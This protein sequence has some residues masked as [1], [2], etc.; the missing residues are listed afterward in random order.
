MQL[1]EKE[2]QTRKSNHQ[3]LVNVRIKNNY[4]P[5]PSPTFFFKAG[6]S[7]LRTG[8]KYVNSEKKSGPR[9]GSRPCCRTQRQASVRKPKHVLFL[10]SAV[11]MHDSCSQRETSVIF[12]HPGKSR[13]ETF[14][15]GY[16]VRSFG[17]QPFAFLISGLS[18]DRNVL[19]A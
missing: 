9:K 12:T 19:K 7:F 14:D 4:V 11:A 15:F 18:P 13:E 10:V 8:F 2:V 3:Y 1:I 16:S 17:P 6:L 5:V